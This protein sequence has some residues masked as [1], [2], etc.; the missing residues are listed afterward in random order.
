MERMRK[1][2]HDQW[3]DSDPSV[4]QINFHQLLTSIEAPEELHQYAG[5]F[6]WDCGCTE[7]E[8]VISHPLCD[9][10]TAFL[11][12]HLA[13]PAILYRRVQSAKFLLPGDI[14]TIAFLRTIEEMAREAAFSSNKIRFDASNW[15]FRSRAINFL[16]H[17]GTELIPDYMKTPTAGEELEILIF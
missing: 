8:S 16:T 15:R 10:G 7:M 2:I 14:T 17:E 11:I 9:K 3:V 12:Y 5:N 6:N 13:K 1:L 4:T